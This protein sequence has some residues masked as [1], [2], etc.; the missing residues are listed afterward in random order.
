M[1]PRPCCAVLQ[2]RVPLVGGIVYS[3]ACRASRT[4]DSGSFLTCVP[5]AKAD[6]GMSERPRTEILRLSYC[7][8][9]PQGDCLCPV[10]AD[11]WYYS[12]RPLCLRGCRHTFKGSLSAATLL[13]DVYVCPSFL[14]S[15]CLPAGHSPQACGPCSR[16]LGFRRSALMQERTPPMYMRPTMLSSHLTTD[17]CRSGCVFRYG[18]RAG[19]RLQSCR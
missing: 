17:N 11:C 3:A 9:V 4:R 6:G 7:Y 14:L 12:P 8:P 10:G 5:Q 15:T 16:E 2:D 18:Q 1:P 19:T 13:E